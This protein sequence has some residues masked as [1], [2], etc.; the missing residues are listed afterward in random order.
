LIKNKEIKS[1]E[2]NN[3]IDS[4]DTEDISNK[5]L[6]IDSQE[7]NKSTDL[8]EKRNIKETQKILES[9][10]Q[11]KLFGENEKTKKSSYKNKKFNYC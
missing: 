11:S 8:K 4:S 6:E 9:K 3:E 2:E 1:D 5:D 10:Q 7:I